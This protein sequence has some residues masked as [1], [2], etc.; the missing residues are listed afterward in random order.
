MGRIFENRGTDRGKNEKILSCDT[1]SS[2]QCP[3]KN[4]KEKS[5]SVRP[6]QEIFLLA[7]RTDKPDVRFETTFYKSVKAPLAKGQEVGTIIAYQNGVEVGQT[8]LLAATSVEKKTF[9]DIFK[10]I[11]QNFS[12]KKQA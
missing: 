5:V 6:Q 12:G 2:I 10:E 1:I 7:S 9:K 4:G 8:Q 3:V 11:A